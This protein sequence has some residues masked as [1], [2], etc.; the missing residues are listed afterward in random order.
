MIWIALV[1]VGIVTGVLMLRAPGEFAHRWLFAV[2]IVPLLLTIVVPLPFSLTA[3]GPTPSVRGTLI[4]VSV[5]GILLSFM[6]STIGILLLVRALLRSDRRTAI[7]LGLATAVSALPALV[8][9]VSYTV[10]R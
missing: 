2:S 9:V 1:V 4:V 6:L 3:H 5:I 10:F 8:W 7:L